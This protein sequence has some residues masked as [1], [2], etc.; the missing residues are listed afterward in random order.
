MHS[1]L[2][3]SFP[4]SAAQAS[5]LLES[6][7]RGWFDRGRGLLRTFAL[8]YRT[9]RLSVRVTARTRQDTSWNV[10]VSY[11]TPTPP[12]WSLGKWRSS[13]S[14]SLLTSPK[15]RRLPLWRIWLAK[16]KVGEKMLP[17][18]YFPLATR[19]ESKPLTFAFCAH[20]PIAAHPQKHTTSLIN[21]TKD[22]ACTVQI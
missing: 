14:F 12:P 21:I 4:R 15:D 10:G 17:C 20:F 22:Y 8:Y 19:R 2:V 6:I 13:A 3:V 1:P 5:H 16:Q 7:T 18:L 9:I 11:L